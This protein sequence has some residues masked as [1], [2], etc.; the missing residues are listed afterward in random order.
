MGTTGINNAAN[1][2]AIKDVNFSDDIDRFYKQLR[3]LGDRARKIIA[4]FVAIKGGRY[5]LDDDE[6]IWVGDEAY[7]TALKNDSNGNVLVFNSAQYSEYLHDME[8]CNILD[9]A[10]C[11]N[12]KF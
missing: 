7:A 10:D 6:Q 5:E 3:E 9:L 11:L 4:D 12:D 1:Q 8:D 2:T